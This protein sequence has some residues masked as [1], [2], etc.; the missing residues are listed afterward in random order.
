LFSV[1]LQSG[2]KQILSGADAGGTVRGSGPLLGDIQAL[3]VDVDNG[4]AF[5][6]DFRSNAVIAVDIVTGE[7][8]LISH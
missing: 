3:D 5:V 7:R 1:D 6:T 8:V 4:V 2:S